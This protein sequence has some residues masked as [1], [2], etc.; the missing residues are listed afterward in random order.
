MSSVLLNKYKAKIL[1]SQDR[2]KKTYLE[3]H[4]MHISDRHT[5]WTTDKLEDTQGEA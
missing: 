2:G 3:T 4:S 5:Q 1:L